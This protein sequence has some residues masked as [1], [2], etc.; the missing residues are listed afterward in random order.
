[1]SVSLALGGYKILSS[2]SA[3]D[4]LDGG[5][6]VFRVMVVTIMRVEVYLCGRGLA[7]HRVH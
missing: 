4:R 3:Y 6:I 7:T 2:W 1:M 5:I